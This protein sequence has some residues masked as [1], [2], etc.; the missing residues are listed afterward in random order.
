M[1][2]VGIDE[3]G[4]G[5]NLG[6]LILAAVVA[7]ADEDRKPDVWG[8]LPE[9]VGRANSGQ[10]RLWVDDSKA[11]YKGGQGRDRLEAAALT[12]LAASGQA[13]PTTMSQWLA[14]M[15]AGSLEDVEVDLWLDEGEDPPVPHPGAAGLLASHLARRPF[16]SAPWRI[17]E[18]RAQVVGPARFNAG[19]AEGGNKAAAH[20]AAFARLLAPI[21]DGCDGQVARVRSDKHGGRHYYYEPLS[22]AFPDAWIDRGEEGPAL[23]R[24][25]LRDGSRS[26]RLD[27]SFSPRAD[28]DDGLVALASIVA[29]G[30]REA[31][32]A[33]F[34]AH[35]A[36]RIPGLTPTAGYP[37]DS[38]R[39][40]D[41]ISSTCLARG[42][43]PARWWRAR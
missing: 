27:L 4:Y 30:L 12:L 2:W 41:A 33:A 6:P 7:E 15:V 34:N 16:A 28:A 35:W 36:A 25:T 14:S 31:W 1:K 43:A 42:L 23:S 32:M 39:F 40:R 22:R 37:G 8:D 13:V 9:T 18:V 11:I 17:V 19:I 20:F 24:Y 26:R 10:D 29:K 3:A 5:P 21:W 38:P